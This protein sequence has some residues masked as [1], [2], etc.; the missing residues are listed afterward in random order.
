MCTLALGEIPTKQLN[1]GTVT[2]MM[3]YGTYKVGFIPASAS[4]SGGVA[5]GEGAAAK[6]VVKEALQMG[7]SFLDCAQF[8][9]NEAAVG[10]AIRESGIPREKLYLASKVWCDNIHEGKTAVRA[11]LQKTLRDLGT[12]YLNLYLIHWPVPTKH[13]AA[14]QVTVCRLPL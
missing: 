13:V 9:G 1:D 6:D 11:Q 10:E 4:A 2:P 7:Y 8:Y 3:G 12:S 14:Y 5:S